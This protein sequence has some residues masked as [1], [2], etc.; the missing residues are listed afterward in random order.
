MPAFRIVLLYPFL[1]LFL[2]VCI[3]V[4]M[5]FCICWC[6]CG[7]HLCL[8]FC[9]SVIVCLF[10]SLSVSVFVCLSRC[11]PYLLLYLT[12]LQSAWRTRRI[13]RAPNASS[14]SPRPCHG[15]ELGYRNPV[16]AKAPWPTSSGD[17][18]GAQGRS[19]Q[20]GSI[21]NADAPLLGT[22]LT[23]R[24]GPRPKLRILYNNLRWDINGR[25]TPS[26]G[27]QREAKGA[28]PKVAGPAR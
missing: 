10:S 18:L 23:E 13:R 1:Y 14:I 26:V 9:L 16:S 8:S 27:L 20:Q 21:N 2:C 6:C 17:H 25:L 24:S 3:S 12:R 22:G 11:F 19:Q 4:C 15:R 7:L 5:H 28:P